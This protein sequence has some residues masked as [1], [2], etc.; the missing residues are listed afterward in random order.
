MAM[1]RTQVLLEPE[2]YE[3]LKAESQRTGRSIGDLVR[4]VVAE[5]YGRRERMKRAARAFE[6][7]FGMWSDLDIDGEDYVEAIRTG[8][9]H[10]SASHGW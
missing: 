7:V 1:H 8:I 4:E 5:R 2:S 3:Q 9:E 6:D 10:R